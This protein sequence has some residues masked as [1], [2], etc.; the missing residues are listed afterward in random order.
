MS[1]ALRRQDTRTL[2]VFPKCLLFLIGFQP[3]VRQIR[4]L[5]GRQAP[6]WHSDARNDGSR[7]LQNLVLTDPRALYWSRILH[8]TSVS[9]R[10]FQPVG[11][12]SCSAFVDRSREVWLNLLHHNRVKCEIFEIVCPPS[13]FIVSLVCLSHLCGFRTNLNKYPLL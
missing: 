7:S 6:C 8:L 4:L 2:S 3:T 10:C 9:A 12:L 5:S 13:N 11:G 1:L